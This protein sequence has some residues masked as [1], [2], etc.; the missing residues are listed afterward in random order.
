MGL[1][2]QFF[3]VLLVGLWLFLLNVFIGILCCISII[4][5]PF[6]LKHFKIA[7]VSFFPFGKRIQTNFESHPIAN[8]LWVVMGGFQSAIGL[9][10]LGGI[11]YITLIGIPL[12]RQCFRLVKIN[13]I[14]FGATVR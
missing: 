9:F 12:G 13:L 5:I 10:V 2:G 4:L 6:G 1:I 7:G 14:P 8:A 3:W 11:F